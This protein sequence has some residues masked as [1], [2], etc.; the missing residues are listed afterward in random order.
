MRLARK[1]R[2]VAVDRTPNTAASGLLLSINLGSIL[3]S[4]CTK[5]LSALALRMKL[6]ELRSL[7]ERLVLS[8]VLIISE[9]F[10]NC[11]ELIEDI[12]EF[13]EALVEALIDADVLADSLALDEAL[14]DALILA[15]VEALTDREIEADTDILIESE[16]ITLLISTLSRE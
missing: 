8:D 12:C 15:E 5:S 1:A 2:P 4:G 7:T 14:C 3:D 10:V 6:S 16:T 11:S 13:D 9:V